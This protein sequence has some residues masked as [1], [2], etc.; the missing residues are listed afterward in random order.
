MSKEIFLI[1]DNSIL[2][3][4]NEHYFAIHKKA[5]K[6]PISQPYHE[7]INT[8]MIQ[9]RPMM[10]ALKQR[11]KDF[12]NW[13]VTEQG[14][15][16]LGIDR[17]EIAQTVYYPN[18]RRHDVDNST[19]K[20]ILDGLVQSGMIVDD[21]SEHLTKLTL[22]CKVS[23]EHPRTEIKVKILDGNSEKVKGAC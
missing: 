20:F 19:P 23:V 14:Y 13:F 11:W 16:N 10:N 1:I 4:Y 7:S 17:C 21:D 3:K 15:S 22:E 12:I 18:H 8:W 5:H 2:E 9:K 6:P